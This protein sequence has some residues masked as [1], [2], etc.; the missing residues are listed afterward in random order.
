MNFNQNDL[1]QDGAQGNFY[2]R[3]RQSADQVLA[4]QIDCGYC[5]DAPEYI[6]SGATESLPYDICRQEAS[7]GIV[8]RAALSN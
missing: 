1:R 3:E 8:A 5:L 4:C 2:F 7:V 6:P